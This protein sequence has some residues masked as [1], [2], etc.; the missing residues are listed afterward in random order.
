MKPLIRSKNR[1]FYNSPGEFR[2]KYKGEEKT[3][4][5]GRE[6]SS[7]SE[8]DMKVGFYE[9]TGEGKYQY[10]NDDKRVPH[11]TLQDPA[12]VHINTEYGN[13]LVLAGVKVWPSHINGKEELQYATVFYRDHGK[14][15]EHLS[16]F[17]TGPSKMKD[18]RL[19]Q[20]P[21]GKKITVF[22]RPQHSE[23]SLGGRGKIGYFQVSTL[24]DITADKMK[25]A[26]IFRHQFADQEWGGVNA[27]E[28]IDD[29]RIGIIG[30]YARFDANSN[31]DYIGVSWI[32]DTRANVLSTPKVILERSDLPRGLMRGSKS[33]DLR[34][35][36]FPGGF[37]KNP[38][39]TYSIFGGEGDM[40]TFLAIVPNPFKN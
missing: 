28:Y 5:A 14:G 15:I 29:H 38:D 24:E 22:T 27:A 23:E 11:L 35:V 17:L 7:K 26:P 10:L 8:T 36:L 16:E 18:V 3:L 19:A 13:E 9:K 40:R 20:S 1:D 33:K 37:V 25:N 34:N 2:A 32:L 6:E 39:G 4:F 31:R 21:D 30:H 12:V